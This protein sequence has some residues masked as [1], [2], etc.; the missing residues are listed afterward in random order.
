MHPNIDLEIAEIRANAA[1]WDAKF[2]FLELRF[3][4]AID[5]RAFNPNQPRDEIGRWSN[6]GASTDRHPS[7]NV[8]VAQNGPRLPR[9]P[10][11][12]TRRING[13]EQSVSLSQQIRLDAAVARASEATARVREREPGWRPRPGVYESVDGEIRHYEEQMIEANARLQHQVRQDLQEIVRQRAGQ[14][15]IEDVFLPRGKELGEQIGTDENIR[16]VTRLEFDMIR[17]WVERNP[18]IQRFDV[19]F[20]TTYP[21]RAYRL[22]DFSKV[23][24]RD[25]IYSGPTIDI[26]NSSSRQFEPG[27]KVHRR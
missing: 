6:G 23:G 8:Q 7:G 10:G 13:V 12:G 4:Q 3:A 16:T 25:S 18:A 1:F 27:Y 2:S 11:G 15:T 24:V 14:G 9:I 19:G 20:P 22:I 17:N 26:I 21:G 5:Q